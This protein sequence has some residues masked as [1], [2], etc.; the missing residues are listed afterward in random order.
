MGERD[1]WII[2]KNYT[3]NF[4]CVENLHLPRKFGNAINTKITA[5]RFVRRTIF[6]ARLAFFFLFN[7]NTPCLLCFMF[8]L[9]F[10]IHTNVVISIFPFSLFPHRG[11]IQIISQILFLI[12]FRAMNSLFTS[13][14][15]LIKLF[16]C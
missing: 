13:N 4:F 3:I 9:L 8:L 14:H 12:L 6:D 15:R 5:P 11:C 16:V 2:L 1:R 10:Y 7:K